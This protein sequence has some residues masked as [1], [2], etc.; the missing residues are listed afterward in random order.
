MKNV[1]LND[2]SFEE[3]V[4]LK[5]L[6]EIESLGV[7]PQLKS[8]KLTDLPNLVKIGFERDPI[9]QRIESMVFQNCPSLETIAPSNVFLSNLTKL[10]VV[11]CDG[12]EYLISPSTARSLGQLNTMKV[13]NCG[14]LEEI[15]SE[16]GQVG[17]RT[18][19]IK[20][21]GDII[22]KQL[23]TIELVSLKNLE[24]FCSSESCA[25]RFPSL[26][27]FVVSA[28]PKLKSFSKQEDMKPP[29]LQKIYVVHEKEKM[30]P[31]WT[32]NLQQTIQD[33]FNKKIF[34]EGMEELSVSDHLDDLQSLWRQGKDVGLQENVFNNLKTLKLSECP[35]EPYAIPSNILFSFKNLRELEVNSC[36]ENITGIFEMNETKMIKGTSFQLKKLT[37]EG[38]PNVTHVWQPNKQGILSSFKNMQIVTV[39]ECE[40]LRTIF[41]V[42]LARNLKKLEELDVRECA[43]LSEIV[44]G[45]E[46]GTVE[47]LVFPRLTTLALC[48]LPNLAHFC[49]QNF[50]LKCPELSCLDVY[51]CNDQ[52]DLF[53]NLEA[54][55]TTSTITK[56]PLFMNIKDNI[57]KMENLTLNW[58]HTQA[59]SKW[60]KNFSE[61]LE[62][63]NELYLVDDD[64]QNNSEVPS[65]ELFGKTPFLESMTVSYYSNETLKTIL[66]SHGDDAALNNNGNILG[67][68]KELYL[69]KLY[70]LQSISGIEY[71]SKQLRL[72]SLSECPKL[73]TVVLQSCSNLKELHIESCKRLQRLFTPSMAKTL[74]HLEELKVEYCKSLEKIIEKDLE[75]AETTATEVNQENQEIKLEKLE[76]ISL[77]SLRSLECFYSG[78]ATLKLP[79]LIQMDIVKCRKMKIFSIGKVILSRQI[80]VSYNS[81]DDLVFHHDDLNT[82]AKWQFL[83]EERIVNL[84]GDLQEIWTREVPIPVHCTSCKLKYLVVDGCEFLSNAIIPSHLLPLLTNL[85][86]LVVRDCDSVEAIFDVKD[87]PTYDSRAIV[88]PLKKLILG[89]LPSMKHVWK[90]DPNKGGLSF[91][92]LEEVTIDECKG[93]KNMFPAS[94]AREDLQEFDVKSFEDVEEEVVAKY[95]QSNA[96]LTSHLLSSLN[97]LKVLVVRKCDSIE[98]I[99]DVKY[100]SP[101]QDR[102]II[103]I[104]L[105]T[106]ILEHL[107][108]LSHVWN[109]DPRGGFRLPLLK[110]V[111][112]NEC[113]C[114][115]SLFPASLI[116][117]NIRKLDVRNCVKL[118]EIVEKDEA[119][120]TGK[121]NDEE[122][123]MFPCLNSF[124]LWELP[125]LRCIWS[126][127]QI[128]HWPEL[129]ELD[130]YHCPELK[131]FADDSENDGDDGIDNDDA[132]DGDDDD[133]DN[134]DE[135]GDQDDGDNDDAEDDNDSGNDSKD[136][137][138]DHD[139]G[140][141]DHDGDDRV[142]SPPKMVVAPRLQ[143]LSLNKKDIIMIEQGELQMDLQSILFLKLQSF[144]ADLDSFP[145]GFISKI[146]L[147][148]I[149][150]IAVADSA[151]KQIFNS[152]RPEVD[153]ENYA[154]ILSQLKGLVL[155]DLY[156]LE[157]IGFEQTLMAPLLENLESLKILACNCLMNLA[158]STVSFS[159]LTQLIVKDCARLEYLFHSS[160]ANSFAEL[161][162]LSISNCELLE[163][164]MVGDG[165]NENK[166]VMFPKLLFI[167]LGNLP[168]LESF[169]KGKSNLNFPQLQKISI[170]E[171]KGMQAFCQGNVLSPELEGVKD[172]EGEFWKSD[173]L[174]TAIEYYLRG[175]ED[176]S[177]SIKQEGEEE[178]QQE[179]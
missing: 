84:N 130:V 87:T 64:E 141:N 69:F 107:P 33:I 98:A 124:T 44:E 143:R 134:G 128:L 4:P 172:T 112:V 168:K 46:A 111:I 115:T 157:S 30:E 56:Q 53:Q 165:D 105:K 125:A 94:I 97:D 8:L 71:L 117:N 153:T 41:P 173:D 29:K 135:D 101:S 151:F 95:E 14:S 123:L 74:I 49:S 77:E 91:P 37:L 126:G 89:N 24:S 177:D 28:C 34:F 59:L 47:H 72:L 58:K 102:N 76:R 62:S 96:L 60:L 86:E 11:D 20:D 42:A 19:D 85:E 119:I 164:V 7:V 55:H 106:M 148:A 131:M 40:N 63:L 78:N 36:G 136:G 81:D 31:Y 149:E 155:R 83:N 169:S 137:D 103:D 110:E 25:F 79:S 61:D 171:C 158:P 70:E 145:D 152:Q 129:K 50:T 88:I 116:K 10:E 108:N 16:K 147:P 174:N 159:K 146:S 66:P 92:C 167:Y 176:D 113:K 142:V 150:Q 161:E 13:I 73:T 118:E 82:A 23:T 17:G 170:T 48:Y 43:E 32:N 156:K 6:T 39:N 54:Q 12:L 3:L 90:N 114:I 18:K 67:N 175:K 27:K 166:D 2:G 127:M 51:D 121:E 57:S 68:L 5:R 138:H 120:T 163:V 144:H 9:L 162:N 179:E 99:F 140:D 38:L 45:V 154:K 133:G 80:R 75:S 178:E 52:L 100:S 122:L 104:P 15:V 1:W 160:T 65:V 109:E 35:S 132:N 21:K 139:D 22:F 26:E 93:I